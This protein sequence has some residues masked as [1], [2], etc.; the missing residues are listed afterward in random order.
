MKHSLTNKNKVDLVADCSICGPQVPIR[1]NGRYG[2]VCLEARRERARRYKQENPEKV[3]A[4]RA[5]ANPSTHRLSLRNGEPDTCVVCGEVQP[6][7]WGR[8]WMCPTIPEEKGWVMTDT[9]HV[10]PRRLDVALLEELRAAGM[11]VETAPSA[12]P[13]EVENAVPGWKTLGSYAPA[14]KTGQGFTVRPEYAALYG[15]GS[16]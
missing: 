16:M 1:L 5:A 2:I 13:A 15:S 12:L 7:R 3:R 10:R 6:I 9:M 11:H 4:G 8:G 14:V